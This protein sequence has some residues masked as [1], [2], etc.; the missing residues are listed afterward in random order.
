MKFR[1]FIVLFAAVAVLFNSGCSG[2][3]ESRVYLK[4]N[5]TAGGQPLQLNTNYTTPDGTL[6]QFSMV[7]FY[8][9]QISLV[10]DNHEE[11]HYPDQYYLAD[12][13][14]EN[15]FLIDEKVI[16]KFKGI[17]FGLG[18]DSTRNDSSGIYAVPAYEYPADHALSPANFMYWSWN[19]GYIF[20]KLE[21]KV[22][23]S[24]NGIL[25]EIGETFSIHTGFKEAYRFIERNY[26]FT[27]KGDD[28][29][30]QVNAEIPNFFTNYNLRSE[31]KDAHPSSSKHEEFPYV[32][33]IVNNS[34]LVFGEIF[35]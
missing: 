7:R 16:G 10:K 35:E 2:E 8:V 33:E 12:S 32:L 13:E 9:S 20:M 28:I 15:L 31:K 23:T 22:D 17:R 4:I 14:R 1:L 11:L 3:K 5:L 19:P 21:G 30:L 27:T 6:I 18:V 26:S 24:G 25:N 34:N 29:I